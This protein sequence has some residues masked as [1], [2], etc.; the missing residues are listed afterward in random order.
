[1]SNKNNIIS[2]NY[3]SWSAKGC[4]V[5]AGGTMYLNLE[6]VEGE[7]WKVI[8]WSAGTYS[9]TG[10]QC[11]MFS[12]E[13][14][15]FASEFKKAAGKE[16]SISKEALANIDTSHGVEAIR[17]AIVFMDKYNISSLCVDKVGDEFAVLYPEH[18]G[19]SID[20]S[21]SVFYKN[22]SCILPN[23]NLDTKR[24]QKLNGDTHVN[25][26]EVV[27]PEE[28]KYKTLDMYMYNQEDANIISKL[29][30]TYVSISMH[31]GEFELPQSLEAGEVIVRNVNDKKIPS[32][33]NITTELQL[34][35]CKNMVIEGGK[36]EK[37]HLRSSDNVI[38][39]NKSKV[40]ELKLWGGK[41]LIVPTTVEHIEGA[42]TAPWRSSRCAGTARRHGRG[43]RGSD[44]C[45]GPRS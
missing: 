34:N 28:L 37:L 31:Q 14:E 26:N 8:D 12:D 23:V 30:P 11:G 29:K 32:D 35:E 33:W 7:K 19:L 43:T 3:T 21:N 25:I 2:V 24:W 18:K 1:M 45:T 9:A 22:G 10:N 17:Q 15:C 13:A 40:K 39:S 27:F 6:N 38:I 36:F 41:N 44:G 42:D 16:I 20:S 4:G 5:T